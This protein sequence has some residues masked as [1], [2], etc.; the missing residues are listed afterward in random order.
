MFWLFIIITHPYVW[1]SN[2]L[3]KRLEYN[4]QSSR[5]RQQIEIR[6]KH[7]HAHKQTQDTIGKHYFI[8]LLYIYIMCTWNIE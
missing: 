7:S 4:F 2:K 6:K 5:I 1:F 3:F 8:T